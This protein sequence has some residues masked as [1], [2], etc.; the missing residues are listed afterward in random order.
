MLQYI[1]WQL[2][3]F[4]LNHIYINYIIILSTKINPYLESLIVYYILFILI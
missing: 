1:L 2:V 3:S 4:M